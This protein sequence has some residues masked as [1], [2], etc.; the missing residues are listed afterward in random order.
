MDVP[1]KIDNDLYFEGKFDTEYLIRMMTER[2]LKPTGYDYSGV[3]IHMRNPSLQNAG[4]SEYESE[5]ETE[6]E[7]EDSGFI[8]QM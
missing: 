7:N 5:Q 1:L 2:V 6:D 4:E 8:M 3:V